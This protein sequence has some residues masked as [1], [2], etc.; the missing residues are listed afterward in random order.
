MIFLIF[1]LT[2]I[3]LQMKLIFTIFFLSQA[4]LPVPFSKL[5]VWRGGG[6]ET[7]EVKGRCQI[8]DG[9]SKGAA[10]TN[11]QKTK[12]DHEPG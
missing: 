1:L 11:I 9:G 3:E 6:G 4:L 5:F 10:R 8:W 7:W 12:I 2:S